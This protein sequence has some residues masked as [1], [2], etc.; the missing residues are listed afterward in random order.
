MRVSTYIDDGIFCHWSKAVTKSAAGVISSAASWTFLLQS[1]RWKSFSSRIKAKTLIRMCGPQ[2]L[3]FF[4]R[5][6]ILW[7]KFLWFGSW[8]SNFL[9]FQFFPK[10]KLSLFKLFL[11]SV[12]IYIF[13]FFRLFQILKFEDILYSITVDVWGKRIDI[14]RLLNSL[15]RK[16]WNLVVPVK[17]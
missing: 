10:W 14:H 2:I 12:L 16:K 8:I 6:S 11:I 5:I 15:W 13:R 17:N 1:K 4:S 9:I 7:L 3:R